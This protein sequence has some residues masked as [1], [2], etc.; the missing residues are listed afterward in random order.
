MKI[1]ET[2]AELRN[3][4]KQKRKS[5]TVGFVATMG[6]LHEGH[7]SLLE[8]SR[9]DNSVSVLS[10]FVNPTQFGPTEDLSKYPRDLVKDGNIARRTGV[11]ILFHPSVEE[12]YSPS[13]S[14]FV[15][16]EK[17][18]EVLCGQFRPGHFRGVATV[19]TK[20]FNL[21]KPDRAYFGQKDAQQIAILKRVVQDLCFDT[22][23]IVC[24]TLRE[25]DG[26]AKSSRNVFL[27]PEERTQAAVLFKA[28][29]YAKASIEAGEKDAAIIKEGMKGIIEKKSLARLQY[30][31]LVEGSTLQTLE[32]A[33]G[34]VLIAIAAHF[35]ATRLIDNVQLDVN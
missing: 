13:A 3:E 8:T 2:I 26:L 24:P 22:Q 32:R 6:A 28:L 25:T 9:Y 11:D 23:L 33:D 15:E 19:V 12:M 4:L 17:M 16:V 29:Q 7:A 14:T 31:D 18:G 20:L 5:D 27:N 21:V 35:G 1:V 30:L 34:N 10:I